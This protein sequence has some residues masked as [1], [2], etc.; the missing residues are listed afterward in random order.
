MSLL[1]N[2]IGVIFTVDEAI[3]LK[4]YIDAIGNK[5]EG[6]LTFLDVQRKHKALEVYD[7]LWQVEH[8]EQEKR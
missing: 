4:K 6:M 3:R 5:A 1:G 2:Q 7:A 8:D